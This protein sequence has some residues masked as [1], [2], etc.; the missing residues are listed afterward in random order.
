M[1]YKLPHPCG[2]PG[3]PALTRDRYCHEHKTVAGREYNRF[4]RSPDHNKIY[5][6][7]W[8]TIRGLYISK[9]PLCER[10]LESGK[11][12]PADEV[13]HIRSVDDGGD[14]SD[15]NLLSLC[16]SCHTKTRS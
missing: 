4:Q 7:R 2:Y 8:R 15:D 12:I 6:R 5:G 9:H 16:R 13:H 14:H 10:C 11:L 1:P 3:C